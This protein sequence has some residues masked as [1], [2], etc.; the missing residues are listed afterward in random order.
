MN[1][2]TSL[3][4][5]PSGGSAHSPANAR[6]ASPSFSLRLRQ[7]LP[8]LLLAGGIATVAVWV[9]ASPW[10]RAHGLGALTVA[11]VLGM[12]LG[13]T[14]YPRLASVCGPGIDLAKSRILRAGIVLY[15]LRITFQDLGNVGASALVM[16]ALVI[17]TTFALAC[18][19]GIR[20][21]KL[22]PPLA[23]LIGAGSSICGAAAVVAT[24]PVVKASS[25]QAA[26]AVATVVVFGT[27]AMFL[28]P[29]LWLALDPL[30][31]AKYFGVYI[32]ATIHEVAQVIASGD[33][34]GPAFTQTAVV[35]KL[36]RVM[37]LAP[38]LMG[39]SALLAMRAKKL[40]GM[41]GEGKVTIPWF[42][43]G[44]LIAVAVHSVG[45]L[46]APVVS[47]AIT[48]ADV[49]LAMAMGALGATTHFSAIR[50]A[51]PKAG[52]LAAALFVWLVI[53][54]GLMTAVVTRLLA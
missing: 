48:L 9:G 10:M 11:V 30:M 18:W 15:G 51:G 3:V 44:F 5:A 22:E 34:I 52:M 29:A 25:D 7:L 33:M 19:L 12:L 8:G 26:V 46:P 17:V 49:L 32:G 27:L 37:M 21:F 2:A 31:P 42:A 47:S 1:T 16:D 28:Y 50:K 45:V 41:V 4:Q 38:F 20:V 54:G 39:L 13:N 24:T 14:V 35:T 53:G 6:L 40:G 36:G 23:M 43:V